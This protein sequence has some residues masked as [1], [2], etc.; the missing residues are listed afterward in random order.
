M[1]KKGVTKDEKRTRAMQYF[2]EKKEPFMLKDL[3]RD[4]PKS[5]GIIGQA[6]PD[7]IKELMDD[8]L[9]DMDKIGGSNFYWAFPSKAA[10]ARETKIAKLTADLEA[11]EQKEQSLTQKRKSAGVGREDGDER[12]AKLARFH[13]LS[14][15]HAALKVE[16][17]AY[18]EVDP[19][20]MSELSCVAFAPASPPPITAITSLHFLLCTNL[21][22]SDSTFLDILQRYPQ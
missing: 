1:P 15:E 21:P 2:F 4:L 20:R 3:E 22:R 18:A 5:K 7:L 10:K 9:V 6:V 14:K 8:N 12:R 19:E 13:A 17:S 11:E 16:L